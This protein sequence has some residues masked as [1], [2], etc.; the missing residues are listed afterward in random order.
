[1]TFGR[2]SDRQWCKK[3][4]L[5]FHFLKVVQNDTCVMAVFVEFT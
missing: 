2:D 3:L 1:M 4:T 5:E